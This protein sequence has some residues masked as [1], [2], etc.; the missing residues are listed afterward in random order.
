M[1]SSVLTEGLDVC[2]GMYFDDDGDYVAETYAYFTTQT[3]PYT[4]GLVVE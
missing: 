3:F 4:V 2:N 1:S